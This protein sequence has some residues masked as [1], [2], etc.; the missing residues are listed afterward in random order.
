L[1]AW[2]PSNPDSDIP[3]LQS[4][5]INWEQRFSTYYVENVSYLK[6]RNVQLGYSLPREL[7]QR[8]KMERMR[9]YVTGQNLLTITSKNFTGV[10]PET[11]G[12]GYPIPASFTLGLNVSF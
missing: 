5:D 12:F 3:K 1:D 7:S 9:F 10:D 6:L 8:I 2:S 4:T 11:P